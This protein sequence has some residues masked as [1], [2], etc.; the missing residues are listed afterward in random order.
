MHNFTIDY[1]DGLV[2]DNNH[3]DPEYAKDKDKHYNVKTYFLHKKIKRSLQTYPDQLGLTATIEEIE[4]KS[5]KTLLTSNNCDLQCW[6]MPSFTKHFVPY[7]VEIY[8]NNELYMTDTLDCKFK[9]VN[10]TLHPKDDRELYVWM[11]VIEKFKRETQ[12]DI[13]I[14]NDTVYSTSEFDN[15]VDVKYKTNDPNKQYYL[16]LH[17]GRFYLDNTTMPDLNKNPDGLN[18]KNSL[19][20][21]NDILYFN[22]TLV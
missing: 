14:K 2:I 1:T 19:D 6:L 15:I 11:N 20:I 3:Y 21:I 18:N 16:G 17:V 12:C 7:H 22:T 5:D 9:L 8:Y 4:T 10:F 13:S